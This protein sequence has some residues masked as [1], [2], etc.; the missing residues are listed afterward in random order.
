MPANSHHAGVL[1]ELFS[2]LSDPTR[3]RI[4]QRLQQRPHNVGDLCRR[5]G[6]AQ[7]TVSHHLRILRGGGL[8]ASRR[9]GKEVFYSLGDLSGSRAPKALARFLGGASALR[10]G[11]MVLGLAR[12]G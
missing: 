8:I 2:L 5:L 1:A 6:V 11:P 9:A 10:L 7:P 12:G 3:V 4:L